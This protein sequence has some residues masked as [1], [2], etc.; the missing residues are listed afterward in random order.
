MVIIPF[1]MSIWLSF[2]GNQRKPGAC[3]T[4]VISWARDVV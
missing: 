1:P 4:G 3:A 2:I